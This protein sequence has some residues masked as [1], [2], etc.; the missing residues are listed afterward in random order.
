MFE[1]KFSVTV[2][3]VIAIAG[4]FYWFVTWFGFR[5]LS[6]AKTVDTGNWLR[7][8]TDSTWL[9]Q[10]C[11]VLDGAFGSKILSLKSFF[12]STLMSLIVSIFLFLFGL[13]T[14]VSEQFDPSGSNW[15][16]VVGLGAV[17]LVIGVIPGYLSLVQTRWFLRRSVHYKSSGSL[18]LVLLADLL[19]TGLIIYLVFLLLVYG[20][21]FFD[22][23]LGFRPLELFHFLVFFQ[24][25]TKI[26]ASKSW[27]HGNTS[28]K[29]HCF[30]R[31]AIHTPRSFTGDSVV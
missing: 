2:L 28:G 8:E 20:I 7:G 10:F 15:E 26:Q 29:Q 4:G 25:G 30:T 23:A 17:G 6:T 19:I 31:F 16:I 13:R 5:N 3:I 27:R 22:N 21:S 12:Y 9:A 14:G 24:A 11:H 18:F 1:S